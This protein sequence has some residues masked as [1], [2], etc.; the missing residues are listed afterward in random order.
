MIIILNRQVVVNPD[1][2]QIPQ[3]C[4]SSG[5]A[6]MSVT[7]REASIPTIVVSACA[8]V[9]AR[10]PLQATGTQSRECAST[11]HI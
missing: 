8:G 4:R 11:C 7:R 3:R 1:D 2:V 5:T 6:L 10:V 9:P